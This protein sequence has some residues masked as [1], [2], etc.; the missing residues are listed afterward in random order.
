[1]NNF[2]IDCEIL[3]KEGNC[4]NG[5]TKPKDLKFFQTFSVKT[6]DR[7]KGKF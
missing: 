7:I 1:M 3:E 2:Q 6:A 4:C 5:L